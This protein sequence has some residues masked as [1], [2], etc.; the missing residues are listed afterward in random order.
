MAGVHDGRTTLGL[1]KEHIVLHGKRSPPYI[2]HEWILRFPLPI[3]NPVRS[4][5]SKSE[6]LPIDG[7]WNREAAAPARMF[8]RAGTVLSGSP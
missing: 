8:D 7:L 3:G 1:T 2:G 6:N 4:P 5:Q